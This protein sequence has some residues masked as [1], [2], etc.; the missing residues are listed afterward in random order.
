MNPDDAFE[1]NKECI[2]FSE[3][4]K[5]TTGHEVQPLSKEDNDV[6]N[7]ISEAAKKILERYKNEVFSDRRPNEVSNL[8]ERE[9]RA[10]LKGASIP[11]NKAAGYPDILIVRGP[12]CFYIE[13][14]LT[15][16]EQ[17]DSSLRSFYYE[18]AKNVKI[19]KDARHILIGFEHRNKNLH[20]FKIV[21]LSKINVCLKKEFNANNRELYKKEAIVL[22]YPP[23]KSNQSTLAG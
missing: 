19:K 20:K 15:G 5:K 9:L 14:K 17:T 2:P 4:I 1:Q 11:E 12:R 16:E 7:E 21:D 8:L 10:S 18:P 13:V 23:E 6:I 22:E 3:I